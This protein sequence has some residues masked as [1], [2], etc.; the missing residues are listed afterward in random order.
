MI[1]VVATAPFKLGDLRGIDSCSELLR[2][3]PLPG[4]LPAMLAGL[5]PIALVGLL[6]IALVGLLPIALVGLLAD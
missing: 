2:P 6:P 1:S 4:R 3:I 5:L